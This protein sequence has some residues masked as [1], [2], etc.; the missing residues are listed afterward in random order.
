MLASRTTF[1][2]VGDQATGRP[3][4]LSCP[5]GWCDDGNCLTPT[6]SQTCGLTQNTCTGQPD[7]P[8]IE[9]KKQ[10]CTQLTDE[11]LY[12]VEWRANETYQVGWLRDAMKF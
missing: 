6:E 10:P 7:D 5:P 3:L 4:K 8:A 2:T 1:K 12:K 9:S 11:N